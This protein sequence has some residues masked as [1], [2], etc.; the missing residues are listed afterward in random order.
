MVYPVEIFVLNIKPKNHIIAAIMNMASDVV[1][2]V[3]S[4]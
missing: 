3:K 2:N 1:R 4:L